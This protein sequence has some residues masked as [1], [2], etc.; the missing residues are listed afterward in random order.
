MNTTSE[1][2]DEEFVPFLKNLGVESYSKSFEWMLA[3]PDFS[4]ILK[5]LYDNLDC[6]NSLSAREDY[7]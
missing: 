6:R 7:R 3:D 4:G 2:T 1:L 5:W